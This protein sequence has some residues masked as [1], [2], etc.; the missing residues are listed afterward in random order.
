MW[1]R[2]KGEGTKPGTTFMLD[3]MLWSSPE[4]KYG[5]FIGRSY[6]VGKGNEKIG[7][8]EHRLPFRSSLTNAP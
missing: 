1:P 6:T 2:A 7:L 4:K 3:Y 5:C 8:R